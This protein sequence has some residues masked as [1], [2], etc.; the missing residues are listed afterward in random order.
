MT[1]I[2]SEERIKKISTLPETS[3]IALKTTQQAIEKYSSRSRYAS[4]KNPILKMPKAT[5]YNDTNLIMKTSFKLAL[6]SNKSSTEKPE[7]TEL[8][9][10]GIKDPTLW[11]DEAFA[12]VMIKSIDHFTDNQSPSSLTPTAEMKAEDETP[13]NKIL[14]TEGPSAPNIASKEKV[15]ALFTSNPDLENQVGSLK[16]TLKK[17][18][19]NIA[20]TK[21]KEKKLLKWNSD[22]ENQVKFLQSA[23]NRAIFDFDTVEENGKVR[24]I[25][26]LD[27]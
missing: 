5:L 26:T 23:L 21:E 11:D 27:Q 6:R 16:S 9:Q 8:I 22:L 20:A 19:Y 15:E 10:K 14:P 4:T 17:A 25:W 13:V 7:L 1:K 3:K 2:K 18:T 24:I 12:D